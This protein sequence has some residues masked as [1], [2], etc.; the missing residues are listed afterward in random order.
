MA[1]AI[2]VLGLNLLVGYSGQISLG[3][4]AFFALGAYTSAISILDLGVPYLLTLPLAG[5]VCGARRLPARPAR[6]CGCAGSTS[7]S[8]RSGWRSR[9]R[10][11]SSAP[12][13]LTGGTQGLSVD[14][15][16][17]P[18]WSGLADDQWLYF[19]TLVV[20]AV[21]FVLAA[22]LVRGRV[23]R[24]LVAIRDNEIAARTMGVDL[25]RY[26]TGT[27]AVSAAYAGVGGALFTLPIGFLA[28]E[29]FPLA[30][31]FAFLAAIVVGGLAT[32]AGALFGAL[33]IEFVPVYAADVDE[34]LAGVIYGGV[35]ILFMYLAPGG[36][37]GLIR[38][39][40][41]RHGT[42]PGKE[43]EVRRKRREDRGGLTMVRHRRFD[44]LAGRAAR[45]G[46]A[47]GRMRARRGRA[48]EAAAAAAPTRASPTRRSSSAAPIRSAGRRR[49]TARSPTA[50]RR[51]SSS[52]TP[53]AA[54]TGARSTS[55]RSTTP[56]SRRR[57]SQNARR[58]IEQEQVFAL[59]NTLGT[60]NNLAIW[61]YVNQQKVPQAFVATGASNW[62]ADVATH[63]YT[64]GW[65][66]NYVTE[67]KIYADYLKK[68]KPNAKVAVLYQNDGFGKDLLGGFERAHRGLERARSSPR[69]PTR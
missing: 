36:V 63:P 28:P 25:A 38:K 45:A 1:L 6:R 52:S 11:S 4:G 61:D 34:A 46:A 23:G 10:R 57:P 54:S 24:A 59:F 68:N 27:F 30:L 32:I 31:S 62:G 14:K 48:A 17:A 44:R 9:R 67:A 18:A 49:P 19:V 60:P 33:F 50:R 56:T 42:P 41:E 40:S 58:L 43:V 26:K 39:A 2:A 55:R 51:S 69:S 3:H 15:V 64:T 35:L 16:T 47:R 21:M 20:A 29:S 13:G 65:Q 37:M 5:I 7:R 66:P 8:S 22:F 12:S 53:R